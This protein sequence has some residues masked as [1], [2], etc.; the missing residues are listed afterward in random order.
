MMVLWVKIYNDWNPVPVPEFQ[1]QFDTHFDADMPQ[2]DGAVQ[3]VGRYVPSKRKSPDL[4][5]ALSHH[6]A[7]WPRDAV[8]VKDP[9]F[10]PCTPA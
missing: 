1:L 8:L 4:L 6:L 9:H 5:L 2:C 3:L 7:E 10:H